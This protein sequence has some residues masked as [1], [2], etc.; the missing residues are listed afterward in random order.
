VSRSPRVEKFKK[1]HRL[2]L[3]ILASVAEFER[4]MIRER[5][6]AGLRVAKANDKHALLKPESRIG[7]KGNP[8]GTRSLRLVTCVQENPKASVR[9]ELR[10]NTAPAGGEC[11][12][13]RRSSMTGKKYLAALAGVAVSYSVAGHYGLAPAFVHRF[14]LSDRPLCCPVWAKVTRPRARCLLPIFYREWN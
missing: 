5:T 6:L 9:T 1:G 14:R 3:Q 8:H 4:E 10:D 13:E 11:V 2:L 12:L 7:S